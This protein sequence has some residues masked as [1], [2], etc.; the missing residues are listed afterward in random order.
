MTYT[1]DE[2]KKILVSFVPKYSIT[3]IV[4]FGSRASGTNNK[5]SDVDL[6][7]EFSVPISLITLSEVKIEMEDALGLNVDLIH[8]PISDEDIIEIENEVIIYAA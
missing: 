5:D 4:L 8:G 7:I 6:I 2:L 3:K 1:L